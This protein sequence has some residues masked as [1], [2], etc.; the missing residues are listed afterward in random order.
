MVLEA[1]NTARASDPIKCRALPWLRGY[2]ILS[3]IWLVGQFLR[4]M[5]FVKRCRRGSVNH[6]QSQF[7][8]ETNNF[9]RVQA[10]NVPWLQFI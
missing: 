5:P 2:S 9:Y 6:H 3:L 10:I 8:A 7:D 4:M 1:H